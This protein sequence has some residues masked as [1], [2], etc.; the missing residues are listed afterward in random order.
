ML[1]SVQWNLSFDT[2]QD[3]LPNIKLDKLFDLVLDDST[4][5]ESIDEIVARAK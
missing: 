4:R 2:V 5:F 1:I 3:R